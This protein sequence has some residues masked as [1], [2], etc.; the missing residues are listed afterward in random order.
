MKKLIN[1]KTAAE[2][3]GRDRRTLEGWERSQKGPPVVR[4]PSGM[5]AYLVSD[6]DEFVA[7]HRAVPSAE[8][9]QND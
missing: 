5:P 1:R 9:A 6:L 7:K 3:L 2:Y 4:L 8:A